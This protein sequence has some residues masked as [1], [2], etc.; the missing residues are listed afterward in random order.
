MTIK[1]LVIAHLDLILAREFL[2]QFFPEF[3]QAASG[4]IVV[5]DNRAAE[6]DK[7]LHGLRRRRVVYHAL[8]E[9]NGT[10]IVAN[11][12]GHVWDHR[13]LYRLHTL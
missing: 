13:A 8:A 5:F 6:A 9:G 3:G 11:E 7:R 2:A 4:L 1:S 12:G 10:W